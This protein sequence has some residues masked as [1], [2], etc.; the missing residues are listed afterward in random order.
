MNHKFTQPEEIDPV[1]MAMESHD[2]GRYRAISDLVQPG[3]TLRDDK[4]DKSTLQPDFSDGGEHKEPE[5]GSPD[6]L[7]Y[8]WSM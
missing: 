7:P 1:R 2:I 3:V 5:Q 8:V 6:P 4:C